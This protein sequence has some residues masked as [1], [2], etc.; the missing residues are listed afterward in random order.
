ML[1][2]SSRVAVR[3]GC[4]EIGIRGGLKIRWGFP[5]CRFESGQPHQFIF[6]QK[7][8]ELGAGRHQFRN[9]MRITV[10]HNR[11]QQEVV[12]SIN[13]SFDEL[14][15]AGLPVKV[16]VQQKEWQGSTLNFA[17]TAKMGMLSTPIKGTVEVTDH[18]LTVDADLG[19]LNNFISE[20]SAQDM[21]GTRIK[22]LLE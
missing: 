22:G 14:F 20:K 12:D 21:I 15:S 2:F 13:R 18:D 8:K 1:C 6:L 10:S 17:L 16:A 5:R 19:M 9:Q 7:S 4:G 11:T 3:C